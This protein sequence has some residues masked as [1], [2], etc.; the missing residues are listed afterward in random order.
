MCTTPNKKMKAY[1][2]VIRFAQ[3][4]IQALIMKIKFTLSPN[5]LRIKHFIRNSKKQKFLSDLYISLNK[6]LSDRIDH[7]KQFWIRNPI[8]HSLPKKTSERIFYPKPF[9]IKNPIRQ[10]FLKKNPVGQNF[11]S[12]TVSD[13]KSYPDWSTNEKSRP[14]QLKRANLALSCF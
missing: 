11:L 2:E 10:G 14:G 6:T 1:T 13:R 7:R 8:R 9:R 3:S 12:E 5:Q 4:I